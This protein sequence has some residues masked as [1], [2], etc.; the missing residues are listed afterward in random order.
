MRLLSREVVAMGG[1]E[2]SEPWRR[3]E[4]RGFADMVLTAAGEEKKKV[5][6][7]GGERTWLRR[8][9]SL[10]AAGNRGRALA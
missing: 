3:R 8:S 4:Q 9:C 1:S 2:S 7:R 10:A 6:G 5:T